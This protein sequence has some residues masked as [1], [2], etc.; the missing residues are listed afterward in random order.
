MAK[1]ADTRA[2]SGMSIDARPRKQA[3]PA[4]QG[5]GS[6]NVNRGK[7]APRTRRSGCPSGGQDIA[8]GA[9]ERMFCHVTHVFV[10]RGR[11][12]PIRTP[13]SRSLA[14]YVADLICR[15]ECLG[16]FRL[17]QRQHHA[18]YMKLLRQPGRPL[19]RRQ[20]SRWLLQLYGDINSQKGALGGNA[21][22]CQVPGAKI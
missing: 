13:C 11:R 1:A 4:R 15:N 20:L 6:G 14:S 3:Q 5:R 18:I 21:G 19:K 22:L 17:S 12:G 10:L 16:G 8:Q 2:D 7:R 9:R